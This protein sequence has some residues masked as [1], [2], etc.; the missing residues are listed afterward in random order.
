[1]DSIACSVTHG[2]IFEVVAWKGNTVGKA[3]DWDL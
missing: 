1:M 2:E 3:Q